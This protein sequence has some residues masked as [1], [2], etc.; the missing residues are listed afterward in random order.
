MSFLDLGVDGIDHAHED[1]S[2][3]LSR[4]DMLIE[5]NSASPRAKLDGLETA[6]WR[7]MTDAA[8]NQMSVAELFYAMAE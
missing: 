3:H 8:W 1:A 5:Q 6:A 4:L 2:F 7:D